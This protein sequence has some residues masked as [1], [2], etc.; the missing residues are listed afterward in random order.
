MA[1]LNIKENAYV[2]NPYIVDEATVKRILCL[3]F[4]SGVIEQNKH[5]GV[6]ISYSRRLAQ[7]TITLYNPRY[8]D[9]MQIFIHDVYAIFYIRVDRLGRAGIP[10]AVAKRI[11]GTRE[12]T[13]VFEFRW[14]DHYAR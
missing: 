9:A 11:I 4:E 10:K 5:Y 12:D 7:Y 14:N 3:Y 13:D 1:T 8:A 2:F 6:S